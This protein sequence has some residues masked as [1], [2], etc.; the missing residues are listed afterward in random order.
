MTDFVI[1]VH[2]NVGEISSQLQ[3]VARLIRLRDLRGK[4]INRDVFYCEM[5]GFDAH[6]HL[7]EVMENKL[8]SLNHAI[9]S[10]W[11]EIKA[12]GLQNSVVVVQGSEFGRT[13]TSNSNWVRSY[14]SL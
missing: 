4:G 11:R 12:Q 13:I 5:G 3:L 7:A 2:L 1:P 8:P 9:S 6:F 10:F 14:L